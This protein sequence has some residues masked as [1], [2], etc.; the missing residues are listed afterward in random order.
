MTEGVAQDGKAS[1]VPQDMGK[2]VLLG[3]IHRKSPFRR[4]VRESLFVGNSKKASF[5]RDPREWWHEG[6]EDALG[7]RCCGREG[8]CTGTSA[9]L[10]R[11]LGT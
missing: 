10:T 6:R 7:S 3:H 8:C 1:G 9:G 4:S 2:V 5:S 11:S